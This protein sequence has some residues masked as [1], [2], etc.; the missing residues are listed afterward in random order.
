MPSIRVADAYRVAIKT[1]EEMP[2]KS[3][4]SKSGQ[5]V[6]THEVAATLRT[7]LHW[8]Y[9]NLTDQ[10]IQRVVRCKNCEHYH[11]YKQKDEFKPQV[12]YMCS[13]DKSRRPPDFFCKDGV[14]K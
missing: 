13:K 11:R 7:V 10:D 8:C 1:L 4:K 5:R 14:E 2:A 12:V 3:L 6:T 9:P